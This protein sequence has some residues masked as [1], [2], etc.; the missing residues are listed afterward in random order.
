MPGRFAREI[1]VVLAENATADYGEAPTI[2]LRLVA[3]TDNLL[4][5]WL[6]SPDSVDPDEIAALVHQI[7]AVG[8]WVVETRGSDP[9]A[10]KRAE[11]IHLLRRIQKAIEELRETSQFAGSTRPEH[12]RRPTSRR[13][14]G[15]ED[16]VNLPG[17]S[18][19]AERGESRAVRVGLTDTDG[20]EFSWLGRQVARPSGMSEIRLYTLDEAALLLRKS[21]KTVRRLVHDGKLAGTKVGGTWRIPQTELERLTQPPGIRNT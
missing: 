1:E 8:R 12:R 20:I 19:A 3:D 18:T 15:A 6:V 5:R 14:Q 9:W 10:E 7:D 17:V 16:G 2:V 13:S 4:L 21:T 11:R